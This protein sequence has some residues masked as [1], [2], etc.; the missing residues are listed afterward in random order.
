[1][2]AT[3]ELVSSLSALFL[4]T[5]AYQKFSFIEVF[6]YFDLK[7]AQVERISSSAVIFSVSFY[8]FGVLTDARQDKPKFRCTLSVWTVI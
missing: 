4:F 2:Y 1:M 7:S 5:F 3:G 6:F 8:F